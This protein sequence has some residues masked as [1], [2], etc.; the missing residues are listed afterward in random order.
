MREHAA[1]ARVFLATAHLHSRNTKLCC[2]GQRDTDGLGQSF[3]PVK[4]TQELPDD[5]VC[6]AVIGALSRLP[7][8]TPFRGGP[9][10]QNACVPEALSPRAKVAESGGESQ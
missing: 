9:Q 7:N 6:I 10:L 1:W 4:R 8:G 2:V 3:G 5:P